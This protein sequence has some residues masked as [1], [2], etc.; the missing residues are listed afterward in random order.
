MQ[1]FDWRLEHL[2]EFENA[3]VRVAQAARKT[4]G[5][6]IVLSEFFQFSD[7]HFSNQCGYVLVV[8]IAGF[9]LGNRDLIED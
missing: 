3:L 5:I 9:C 4:V 7:I 6:W 1:Y 8:L 2:D